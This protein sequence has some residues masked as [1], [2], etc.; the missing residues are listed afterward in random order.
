MAIVKLMNRFKMRACNGVL[1][2]F[3]DALTRI[4]NLELE[5]NV[6]RGF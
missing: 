1:I 6:R 4:S 2:A 3:D 5:E